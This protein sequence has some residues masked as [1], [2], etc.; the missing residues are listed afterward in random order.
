MSAKKE[1]KKLLIDK[2][3]TCNSKLSKSHSLAAEETCC[4]SE[5]YFQDDHKKKKKQV[6]KFQLCQIDCHTSCIVLT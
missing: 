2:M 5:A 1:Y 3:R 4:V 6:S